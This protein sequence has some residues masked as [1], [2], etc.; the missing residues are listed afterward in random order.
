MDAWLQHCHRAKHI[1][2]KYGF[3]EAFQIITEG[4]EQPIDR[5]K[6]TKRIKVKRKLKIDKGVRKE[7]ITSDIEDSGEIP[8][9]EAVL[10]E[11]NNPHIPITVPEKGV[12]PK[13]ENL[14]DDTK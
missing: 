13:I 6:I 14:Y 11:P 5:R 2:D 1:S 9:E 7:I 12:P 10:G 3:D 4:L 8:K